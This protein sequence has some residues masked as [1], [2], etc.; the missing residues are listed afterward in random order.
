MAWIILS[1]DMSNAKIG[2]FQFRYKL[3]YSLK[4]SVIPCLF[5]L[6]RAWRIYLFTMALP[7]LGAFI[8]L[9]FL[10]ESPRFLHSYGRSEKARQVLEHMYYM[11]HRDTT[12]EYPVSIKLGF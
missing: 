12:E 9:K 4:K 2:S 11:N 1:I 10:P 7:E 3:C 8:F 6:G 5:L